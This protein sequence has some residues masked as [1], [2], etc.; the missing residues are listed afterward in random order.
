VSYLEI[1]DLQRLA[2]A[3]PCLTVLAADRLLH[4]HRIMVVAPSRVAHDLF[5]SSPPRSTVPQ[6]VQR[7]ILKGISMERRWRL[8]LYLYSQLVR[9]IPLICIDSCLTQRLQSVKQYE[10]SVR[11]QKERVSN[12]IRLHLRRRAPMTEAGLLAALHKL[13][14]LP[15]VESSSPRISRTIL[16]AMHNLKWSLQRDILSK[17]VK[18]KINKG[19]GAWLE[20]RGHNLVTEGERVRLALCGDVRKLVKFWEGLS[21]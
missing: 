3:I 5:G 14:I 18:S 8:G 7:N 19:L 17:A 12:V 15:D 11:L 6:L 2:V 4:R 21:L 9:S 10:S 16:P 13:G 1:S 20:G